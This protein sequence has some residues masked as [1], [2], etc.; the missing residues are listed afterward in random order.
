MY[1][2]CMTMSTVGY[3]DILPFTDTERMFAIC[4]MVVGAGIYGLLI[5]SL[6]SIVTNTD[7]NTRLYN[8]RMGSILSYMGQRHFPGPLQRKIKNFYR[9]YFTTRSAFD[10]Q[11]VLAELPAKF[12]NEVAMFLLNDLVFQSDLFQD[13]G[14][15][16]LP[17]LAKIINPVFYEAE[18][19][20]VYLYDEITDIH[21][22]SAGT[23]QVKF[24]HHHATTSFH[25]PTTTITPPPHPTITPPPPRR[26]SPTSTTSSR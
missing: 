16:H 14:A 24:D 19:I 11:T 22:I 12:K 5:G 1:W 9:N 13:L 4:A 15:H 21:I 2:S 18:D 17:L 10:E 23:A 20:M 26:S 7:A 3:G 8:E 6:V 25:H